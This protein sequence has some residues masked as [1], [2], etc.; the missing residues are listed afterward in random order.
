MYIKKF[1]FIANISNFVRSV[2][3]VDPMKDIEKTLV[4]CESK[5]KACQSK[6]NI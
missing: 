5:L 4:I 2:E 3:L 6:K 1:F